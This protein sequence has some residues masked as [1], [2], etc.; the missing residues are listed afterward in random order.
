MTEPAQIPE[1][2]HEQPEPRISYVVARL[3]RALRVEINERVR[4]HGLTTLQYTTLSI[5][6]RRGELSNAQLA[7]RAYM[8]PQS[9]SEVIDALEKKGLVERTPHPNHRRVFP[10]ALTPKGRKVLEACDAAVDDLEHEMLAELTPHQAKSLRNG[11]I[12]AVRALHAGF[13][14]R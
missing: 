2:V 8:T 4:P 7:R 14:L 5:L 1:H 12:S 11:L 3:E 10:A 6:G 9:M 13:P